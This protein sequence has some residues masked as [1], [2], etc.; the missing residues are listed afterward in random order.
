MSGTSVAT[1]VATGILAQVWEERPEVS[2]DMLRAAVTR[3]GPRNG[4][5]PPLITLSR[6]LSRLDRPT[7]TG[8]SSASLTRGD[9]P[10]IVKM[11]GGSAMTTAS[12]QYEAGG[13]KIKAV[14]APAHVLGGC[15]CGAAPEAC[16]CAGGP[17]ASNFVY[18]LG[19]VD[20]RF[21]DQS[22]SDEMQRV[23]STLGVVQG[24][25]TFQVGDAAAGVHPNEDLRNWCH[26]VLV[27]PEARYLARQVSWILTVEGLPAYYLS[28]RDPSDLDR[29]IEAL[30]EPKPRIAKAAPPAK[31]RGGSR[32]AK[33]GGEN[34]ILPPNEEY[35]LS[36][37]VGKSS[38]IPVEASPDVIAP[39]LTVDYA[40]SFD[41]NVLASWIQTSSGKLPRPR[42]RKT[43]IFSLVGGHTPNDFL[44]RLVQS[45][46]NFGD[47]DE[48]RA[49]NFLAVQYKPLYQ[50]YADMLEDDYILDSVLVRRSRL[51]G[52]KRIVD[53]V[54]VFR[55]NDGDVERFFVRVDVTHLFP[56]IVSH[57]AAYFER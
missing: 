46:D 18:V 24:E 33:P 16:T 22:I 34:I 28:L 39:T 12:G 43:R 23:A 27:R 32:K 2:G 29:L 51:S 17:A 52:N 15:S 11:Q 40:C 1:A 53:P 6:V 36:L 45:A 42:S 41:R 25:G 35:D 5:I 3:L 47:T 7:R 20:V 57:I 21:P 38:M 13:A 31:T 44:A 30:G 49:L 54:F 19:T 14:V 9:K 48:W 4:A 56:T 26:R 55:N 50:C 10:S 37:F 8:E